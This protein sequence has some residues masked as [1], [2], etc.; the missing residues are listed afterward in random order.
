MSKKSKICLI[1]RKFDKN[2]GRA[3]WIYAQ[4]L[5]EEL[6][7]RNL[8]IFKI[9]Q[10]NADI[11]MSKTKKALHD[12]LITPVEL[13]NKRFA[14]KIRIFHFLNE[15]QAIYSWLMKLVGAKT[16]TTYHDFINLNSNKKTIRYY[17]FK[18]IYKLASFSD[19]IICNSDK[20]K[21]EFI[22]KYGKKKTIKIIPP[23]HYTNLFPFNKKKN[24]NK[25]GYIG[26]LDSRKRVLKFIEL[27]EKIKKENKN[28]IIEI[29]GK[30]NLK[31]ELE[32][33]II[34]KKLEKI[35]FLKGYAP[36]NKIN[37]IYNSFAYFVFPT[38]QEGLGLMIIES[39]TC[40]TPVIVLED[41]VI[42]EEMK[43]ICI[44]CKNLNEIYEKIIQTNKKEYK[45]IRE[46]ALKDSQKFNSK[47]NF[48]EL[49]EIYLK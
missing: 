28:Y 19:I 48:D 16:I 15:N 12:F 13:L 38:K 1:S 3:E 17:Y 43:K 34:N 26:G 22:E 41:A 20:T 23:V 46:K 31:Q 32:K 27:G 24:F 30:G 49:K 11:R 39:I 18:L 6:E 14:E 25:I 42:S 4:R 37:E 29:W 5:K 9:E 47:K 44:I 7:K 10:E 8:E 35:V 33:Q 21:K 45:I 36:Y 2:S 40:G